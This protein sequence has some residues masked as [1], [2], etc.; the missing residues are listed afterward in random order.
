MDKNSFGL[1]IVGQ[2]DFGQNDIGQNVIGRNNFGR[3]VLRPRS[4]DEG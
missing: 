3:I 4:E 2:I 1:N